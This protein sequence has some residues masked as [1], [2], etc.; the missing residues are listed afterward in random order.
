MKIEGLRSTILSVPFN[1]PTH[2]PYGHWDGM[3]IVVVEI[4]TDKGITG[5]GESACFRRPRALAWNWTVRR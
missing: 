5:I 3:T 2:W 1:K 4:E